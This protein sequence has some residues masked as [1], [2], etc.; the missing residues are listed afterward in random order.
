MN[1]DFK[2]PISLLY[3]SRKIPIA[4][5]AIVLLNRILQAINERVMMVVSEMK[6]FDIEIIIDS[7]FPE[8]I[9]SNIRRVLQW[10]KVIHFDIEVF[11]ELNIIYEYLI[12]DIIDRTLYYEIVQPQD[13]KS[14]FDYDMGLQRL[15]HENRIVLLDT[16]GTLSIEGFAETLKEYVK[17]NPYVFSE[18]N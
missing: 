18:L 4:P 7:V 16:P 17:G 1:D 13:V 2:T 3:E 5:D 14:A 8:D 9:Q 10:D 11:P 6:A 15:L 12:H